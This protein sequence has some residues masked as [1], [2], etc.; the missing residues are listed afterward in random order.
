MEQPT[1]ITPIDVISLNECPHCGTETEFINDSDA[2]VLDVWLKDNYGEKLEVAATD[3]TET[4][5]GF[6]WGHGGNYGIIDSD[7]LG[8][9]GDGER[10]RKAA[11]VFQFLYDDSA[12]KTEESC[13]YCARFA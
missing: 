5:T 1:T 8:G 9:D 2:H 3:Y 11:T 12:D 10:E 4:R 13:G 7:L 6:T